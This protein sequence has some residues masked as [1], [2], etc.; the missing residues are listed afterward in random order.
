MSGS[1][2]IFVSYGGLAFQFSGS[3]V[4][5]KPDFRHPPTFLILQKTGQTLG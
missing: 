5:V 1:K 3:F 2:G 4:T